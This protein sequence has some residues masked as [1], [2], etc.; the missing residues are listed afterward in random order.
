[1]P[2]AD[3]FEQDAPRAAVTL[4]PGYEDAKQV[5]ASSQNSGGIQLPP[6]YEDAKPATGSE[7]ALKWPGRWER[8]REKL[9]GILQRVLLCLKH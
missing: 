2:Q 6:G 1:M 5:V 3:W 4:P 7:L 9:R 8:S